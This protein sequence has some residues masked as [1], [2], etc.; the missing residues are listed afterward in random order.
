MAF[1]KDTVAGT[2]E[3]IAPQHNPLPREPERPVGSEVLRRTVEPAEARPHAPARAEAKES[4]IAADLTIEGKI[5]GAGNVRIAGRFKGD[6]QV[7]GNLTIES[8]AHLAGQ[9]K[10]RQV[11]IGGELQGNIDGA[12]KVEILET[13]ALIGDVKAGSLTV[14]AG[15][16]M[17]G[18][19]EFGW[20]D[21]AAP[22][23]EIPR[24]NGPSA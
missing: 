11:T 16:R 9:V 1:F 18:Q 24:G 14:A 21:K 6:V 3:G 12:T 23:T 5:E 22:K 2:R 4:L 15:S 13:G 7:Q 19:V 10:A 17:R 8:G 20:T